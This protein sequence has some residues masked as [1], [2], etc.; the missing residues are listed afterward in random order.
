MNVFTVLRIGGAPRHGKLACLA[1]VVFTMLLPFGALKTQAYD[2]DTHFWLTYYLARKTG[3]SHIQAEQIA[4]ADIS[5]D[6]DPQTDPVMASPNFFSDVLKP[7]F[8]LQYVRAE[9]HALPYRSD[10]IA[11]FANTVD[12]SRNKRQF[13]D[14]DPRIQSDPEVLEWQDEL[15]RKQQEARWKNVVDAARVENGNNPGVFL[16]YL[17]DKYAHRGFASVMGH[18]GYRRV[19]FLAS[20]RE[21]ARTMARDT[22]NYL[23]EYKKISPQIASGNIVPS[24]NISTNWQQLDD[25]TW[26]EIDATLER[27]FAANPSNGIEETDLLK[28]WVNFPAKG[29]PLGSE[30]LLVLKELYR[31][32]NNPIFPNSL[33]ARAVVREQ[34]K[35]SDEDV[36]RIWYYN[37]LHGGFPESGSY[38]TSSIRK[39]GD[40]NKGK[41]FKNERFKKKQAKN[42]QGKRLCLPW[43]L[44]DFEVAEVSPCKSRES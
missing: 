17:Q 14:Y 37:L 15:V 19:D 10:I 41:N 34:L 36:S 44:V 26:S 7:G 5:V 32:G 11:K 3:Y 25:A 16:H 13:F 35:M 31:L 43:K 33:L 2:N 40:D 29:G 8:Y 27:L 28:K 39:Y 42:I 30:K 4:S 24:A 12:I 21:K 1:V 23:I 22:V 20:D 18:A 6:L 9:L 38:L